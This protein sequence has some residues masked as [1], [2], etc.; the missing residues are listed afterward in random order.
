LVCGALFAL[1]FSGKIELRLVNRRA[2]YAT[3]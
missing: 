3:H 1:V 2:A